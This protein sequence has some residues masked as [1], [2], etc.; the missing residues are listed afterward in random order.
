MIQVLDSRDP[1]SYRVPSFEKTLAERGKKLIF[2]LNKTG[3]QVTIVFASILT[4][5]NGTG[6]KELVPRE[7]VS[8]WLSHLR[9][10]HPTF[11]FKPSTAFLTSIAI[12]VTPKG[13]EKAPLDDELGAAG[14]RECITTLA[15]EKNA[16]GATS[17]PFV[18][19]FV[20]MANVRITL[21]NAIV[22]G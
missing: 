13:K 2:V 20:G 15:K 12:P 1:L 16:S 18:V 7:A 22:R 14:L 11:P 6:L 10:E 5:S 21:R 8:A 9:L 17:S 3:G 19:A 4:D